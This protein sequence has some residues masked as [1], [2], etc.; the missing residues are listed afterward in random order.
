MALPIALQ[1][2]SVRGELNEDFLGTLKAVKALGYDGVEFAGGFKSYTAADVKKMCEDVGL[3]PISAHVPYL[4]MVASPSEVLGFYKEIGCKYVAIPYLTEE[5]RPGNE[6]FAEVVENAKILGSKA[7][8]LGM[9]LLYHNH[10]F[11]FVKLDG[12]YALDMLY[13]SVSDDL[14]KTELD[15]CWVNVGGEE[16]ASYVRKYSGR[17]PI[18]H[19]KDFYGEKSEDM[20]ELIGIEKKAPRRPGN[21]EFRPLGSGL[22]NFPEILAAS[23]EAGAEWLVVE[24]DN[25]SMNLS[26]LECAKVSIDYLRTI[27]K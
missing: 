19:F 18:V 7:R 12:K 11:E 17:A 3:I 13:E 15:V 4:D 14:L 23:L 6:K 16:P 8:E 2:Y 27:N 10:D 26:P 1:L 5:Y 22:Q 9:T 24:Q 20:Y 21:F 25:P